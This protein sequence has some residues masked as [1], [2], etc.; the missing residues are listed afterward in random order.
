MNALLGFLGSIG[1]M[2]LLVIA[3]LGVLIFGH[4]LPK[5]ARSLGRGITEFKKG[6]K[7][8]REKADVAEDIRRLDTEE[9]DEE[10]EEKPVADERRARRS[11]RGT[12]RRRRVAKP[13]DE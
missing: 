8:V 5:V 7:D 13:E 6:L 1:P 12:S 2:E 10:P 11:R 4:R 9:A 3:G